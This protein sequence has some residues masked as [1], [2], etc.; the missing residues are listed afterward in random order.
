MGVVYYAAVKALVAFLV[1]APLAA[2]V[3][4]L[5]FSQTAR[6][7]HAG[8]I[9]HSGSALS[10]L[11]TAG[12][13]LPELRKRDDTNTCAYMYGA[14]LGPIVGATVGG[15]AIIAIS[16]AFIAWLCIKAGRENRHRQMQQQQQQS[17]QVFA[18]PQTAQYGPYPGHLSFGSW[19]HHTRDPSITALGVDS[20][21]GNKDLQPQPQVTQLSP[22]SEHYSEQLH[23]HQQMEITLPHDRPGA[24]VS[25]LQGQGPNMQPH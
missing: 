2:H 3:N 21:G 7:T 9:P 22:V 11:P 20:D 5:R 4:G 19:S 17:Q 15:V 12:P 24:Y 10:L 18:S 14:E 13:E 25:E 23:Q 8:L 6:R 16:A 1:L